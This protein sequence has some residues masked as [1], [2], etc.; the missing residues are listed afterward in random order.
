MD[1]HLFT[2]LQLRGVTLENRIAVSPMCQY[3]SEDGFPNDWHYVHLTTRAIGGA[4]LVIAEAT[5]VEARGRISP[6]DLGIWKDEHIEPHRKLAG[7]VRDAGAV[8]GIQ[9]GHAG[10]KASTRRPWDGRGPVGEEDGGWSPIVGPSALPFAEG[11]QVPLDLDEEGLAGVVASFAAGARRARE[12]GYGLVEVHGAHGYLISSFLSPL[13]NHRTD[14]YGGSFENRVRLLEEVVAAVRSEWP[15]ELPLFVRIST[16]DWAEGGWTVEE[17][18]ALAERLENQGV[19]LIDCSSGGNKLV[20]V[21]TGPGYQTA[22]AAEIRRRTGMKTGAVGMI[23]SAHQADHI[24]R[25]GQADIVLLAR[26]ML[27]NPYWALQAASE[28]GVDVP[29]PPQYERAKL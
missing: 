5:A 27:R 25:S 22:A 21:P 3:S 6:Q 7:L 29:W 1:T 28:L 12:S 13:A 10:R 17:S 4:G 24:I 2:P 16:T 14:S 8:P 18:V 26:E 11:Y 9:L 20:P 15:D 23:R 19:D